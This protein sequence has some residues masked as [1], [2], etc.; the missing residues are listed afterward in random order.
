MKLQRRLEDLLVCVVLLHSSPTNRLALSAGT[1]RIQMIRL[2]LQTQQTSCEMPKG[3]I[4]S[5][6]K[7]I[8]N[9]KP[10]LRS[11]AAC[12]NCAQFDRVQAKQ[13]EHFAMF[14]LAMIA[15][16]SFFHCR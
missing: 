2:I 9:G 4:R 7:G 15:N 14:F 10:I 5:M 11:Q 1:S 12:E 8:T 13:R 16:A 3:N 6:L